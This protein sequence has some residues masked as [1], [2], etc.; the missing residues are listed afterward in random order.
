MRKATVAYLVFFL[1]IGGAWFTLSASCILGYMGIA[2]PMAQNMANG[3][4]TCVSAITACQEDPSEENCLAQQTKVNEVA[5][6]FTGSMELPAWVDELQE[7]TNTP[8]MTADDNY[9]SFMGSSVPEGVQS[10][11]TEGKLID[12]AEGKIDELDFLLDS[13]N[14]DRVTEED[15][16]SVISEIEILKEEFKSSMEDAGLI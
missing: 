4:T 16:D 5:T 6:S 14:K 13:I 12:I 15:F 3:L 7:Y 10:I 8:D 1:L 9:L 11:F 2:K